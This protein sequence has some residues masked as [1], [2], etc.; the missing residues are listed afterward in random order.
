MLETNATPEIHESTTDDEVSPPS[1]EVSSKRSGGRKAKGSQE[2]GSTN[3]TKRLLILLKPD[4][5]YELLKEADLQAA[6]AGCVKDP[7]LQLV[8]GILLVP[9][10]S[11]KNATR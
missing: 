6:G 8:E 4:K 2:A 10:I 11:F 5:T 3:S 9:E 7:T 1:Q